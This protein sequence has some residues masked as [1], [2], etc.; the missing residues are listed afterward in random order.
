MALSFERA[1][2]R[3]VTGSLD[4]NIKIYDFGGMD[5]YVD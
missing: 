3:V 2:N 4:Y 1:G 5:W